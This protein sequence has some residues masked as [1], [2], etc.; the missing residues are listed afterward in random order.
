MPDIPR[1]TGGG[2]FIAA[3]KGYSNAA[4]VTTVEF[5]QRR[6][7]FK[8]REVRQALMCAINRQ[9]TAETTSSGRARPST[10]VVHASNPIFFTKD[11]QPYPFDVK[12]AAAMLDAAGYP[13]K[14]G[15]RFNLSLVS[16][17][18]CGVGPQGDPCVNPAWR[19][20]RIARVCC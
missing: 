10:G 1:L 4:W 7:A 19:E 8:K 17:A 18:L 2:K 12:N 20:R 3:T 5:N 15:W 13:V 9:F 16:A 11:V 6:E 14:G